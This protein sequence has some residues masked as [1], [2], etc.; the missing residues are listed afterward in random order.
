M[1]L[2]ESEAVRVLRARSDWLEFVCKQEL[3]VV[4]AIVSTIAS[5]ARRRTFMARAGVGIGR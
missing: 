4:I 3:K 5:G 1:P 2:V